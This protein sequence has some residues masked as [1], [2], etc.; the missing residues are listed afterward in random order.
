[1][2]R[3]ILVLLLALALALILPVAASANCVT[4]ANDS[5][6]QNPDS[7][8]YGP[9]YSVQNSGSYFDYLKSNILVKNPDLAPSCSSHFCLSYASE[10]MV[11]S[12]GSSW[13]QWGPFSGYF[14]GF[15][16]GPGGD[17]LQ[18]ARNNG[19][20]T[21]DNWPVTSSVGSSPLYTI[22]Y[23]TD[24]LGFSGNKIFLLNGTIEDWCGGAND[25]FTFTPVI[26]QAGTEIHDIQTQ[27]PGGTSAKEHFTNSHTVD[28]V[29]GQGDLFT[30]GGWFYQQNLDFVHWMGKSIVDSHTADL[31]DGDCSS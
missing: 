23:G 4:N 8:P 3:R 2:D 28:P 31:W 27:M 14:A 5:T 24:P 22:H 18:C 17:L 26:A 11:S 1:M 15:S 29:N 25:P 20:Y 12:S 13:A 16:V 30:G 7:A 21:Y 19:Q 10:L 6:R 9:G